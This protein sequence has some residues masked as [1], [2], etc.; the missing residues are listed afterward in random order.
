VSAGNL[1]NSHAAINRK[2]RE[3]ALLL[4]QQKAHLGLPLL[5]KIITQFY[6]SPSKSLPD[7]VHLSLIAYTNPSKHTPWTSPSYAQIAT[8]IISQYTHQTHTHSFF[9]TYLLQQ[10][11]RPFFTTSKPSTVTSTGRK[12]ISSSAPL[13]K[14]G[15]EEFER[16]RKPWKYE[17][18]YS[19]T[20]IR[21]IVSN[22]PVSPPSSF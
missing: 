2:T 14:T 3:S 11:L 1:S 8:T 6:S 18:V 4:I 12:A 20:V 5:Q 9:S 15:T 13:K 19:I 21:W 7:P 10:T 22:I 16:S 17:A